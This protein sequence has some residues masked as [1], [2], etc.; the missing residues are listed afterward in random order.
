[1]FLLPRRFQSW[2]I[3][4]TL[5]LCAGCA[6][7]YQK[8][9]KFQ[10]SFVRGDIAEADRILDE[11]KKAGQGKDRL[12]YF[13]QKGVVL[14]ML[15][16]YEESNQFFE[17]AYLFTED[18]QKNYTLEAFSLLSNPTI[19]PYRGEDFEVVQIHYY[20]ALNY[21]YLNRYE[22]AQVECRRLNIKLNQLNDRYGQRKNR[23]RRDAFALNLMGIIF[24]ASGD[25]NS[26]FISYR[27]SYEAYTED[28]GPNFNVDA[29]LQLKKDLLRSAYLNGFKEELAH[30]ETE[31]EMSYNSPEDSPGGELIF[32]LNNGLG[33]VKSEWGINFFIVRGKGGMVSFVNDDMGFSFPFSTEGKGNAV[34]LGD[35]KIVRAAFPKYVERKPYFRLAE[36]LVAGQRYP[37]E[38]SQDINRIAF[39]T[40]EDRMIREL[41]VSLLRLAAKQ[42]AEYA[43]SKKSEGLG[44]LLSGVNAI[45]EKTDTRNWQTLPYNIHYARIPLP[46][47]THELQLRYQS[48]LG[49]RSF[50]K[51]LQV[52][53][54]RGRTNFQHFHLLDTIP[55]DL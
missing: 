28:Y 42:A 4:V 31:F 38:I 19:L 37:L 45:T 33:P 14:Q 24:E 18:I 51:T 7:Y 54:E 12:L 53:I 35:L 34:N 44:A 17:Q 32:F 29:P 25:I 9:I 36:L 48:P 13:L 21:L 23:Y 8:T 27:N 15:G 26:A 47:G 49:T 41:A 43:V 39:A 1:M 30:Y 5:L 22:E 10:E 55:P 16:R 2:S 40:L 46:E 3:A 50:S 6:T 52:T 11:N 20:K